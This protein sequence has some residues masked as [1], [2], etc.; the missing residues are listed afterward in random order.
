M[1]AITVHMQPLSYVKAHPCA[2]VHGNQRNMPEGDAGTKFDNRE[3]PVTGDQV[4]KNQSHTSTTCIFTW[5]N[6]ST[7][8]TA[9]FTWLHRSTYTTATST[10]TWLNQREHTTA[11]FTWLN[12]S[13]HATVTFTWL[14]WST[15]TKAMFTWLNWHTHTTAIF[16]WLNP[17]S[18]CSYSP[19]QYTRSCF[20]DITCMAYI[21]KDMLVS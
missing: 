11:I 6:R 18:I 4:D 5:L 14:N 15:R 19:I 9:I 20:S 10:F 3:I 17:H 8:T 7:R 13:T 1:P 2:V 12:W 16:K 21:A